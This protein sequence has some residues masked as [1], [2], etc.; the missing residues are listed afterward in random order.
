MN[1]RLALLLPLLAL[2]ACGGGGGN[3]DNGQPGSESW[4]RNLVGNQGSPGFRRP[5]GSFDR[6]DYRR[7]M[8]QGCA[9]GMRDGNPSL[10][11][12]EV[13]RFCTCLVERL[14]ATSSDAELFAMNRDSA[15]QQR[16]YD[17]AGNVCLPARAGAAAGEEPPPPEEP[18]PSLNDALPPPVAAPPPSR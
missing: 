16:K 8:P 1:R 18:V 10:P 11:A 6:A 17:E 7:V 9:A 2:A 5:D 3:Q 12:A 14:L 15:L 13:D 4:A